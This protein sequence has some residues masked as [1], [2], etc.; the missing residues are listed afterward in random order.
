[1]LV[2]PVT[3]DKRP[4]WLR[5]GSPCGV[6][7]GS[8]SGSLGTSPVL[9]HPT[10][11]RAIVPRTAEYKIR[12]IKAEVRRRLGY[13]YP[14]RVPA[15]VVAEVAIGIS[16]DEVMRA[17]DSDVAYMRNTFPLLDLGWRREDCVAFVSARDSEVD[18]VVG[19]E[20]GAD[21]YVAK[22]YSGARATGPDPSRAAPP[23]PYPP[24]RAGVADR[25]AGTH[26]RGPPRRDRPGRPGVVGPQRVPTVGGT[27]PQR[28]T[29]TDPGTADRPGR[30]PGLHRR[31]QDI[32][33]HI[34][35]LR[36]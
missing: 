35:R 29:G 19:L 1:V 7:S 10:S 3:D 36:S 12:P 20:L 11:I 32:E 31:H 15:W 5:Q 17:R 27:G 14:R 30:G 21:D 6:R 16:V 8:T 9:H 26:R 13:P 4:M 33:V 2:D 34:K 23:R 22:P 28:R 24:Q 18:K 25:R